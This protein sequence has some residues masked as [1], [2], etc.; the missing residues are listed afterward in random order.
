[1][2]NILI[3]IFLAPLLALREILFSF[4]FKRSE[5][6][7]T[8]FEMLEQ[9]SFNTNS[10]SHKYEEPN[11]ATKFVTPN[12]NDVFE[13]KIWTYT[14]GRLFDVSTSAE[15]KNDKFL[16]EVGAS[17]DRI[18]NVF[19]VWLFDAKNFVRTFSGVFVFGVIEDE[20]SIKDRVGT[21]IIVP[22]QNGAEITLKGELFE[23]TYRVSD[24]V[25]TNNGLNSF[26]ITPTIRINGE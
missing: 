11:T 16:G 22:L 12:F 5:F 2:R 13:S 19:E 20:E 1:M 3:A 23:C 26:K 6:N 25:V 7:V 21:D 9:T 8:V 14:E 18:K 24:V 4:G 15:N 10:V 17:E